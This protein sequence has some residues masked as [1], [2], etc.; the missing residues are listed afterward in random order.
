MSANLIYH[1][2]LNGGTVDTLV[3]ET[4]TLIGCAGSSPALTT[5]IYTKAKLVWREYKTRKDR[6][7]TTNGNFMSYYRKKSYRKDANIRIRR[8]KGD[9]GQNGWYKRKEEVMWKVV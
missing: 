2:T 1:P 9:V 3:L 7:H 8:H 5:M 6:Y 4:N